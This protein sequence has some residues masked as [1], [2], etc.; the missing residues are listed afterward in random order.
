MNSQPSGRPVTARTSPPGDSLRLELER[1]RRALGSAVFVGG[2]VLLLGACVV[3][4]CCAAG[5][6]VGAG[7]L[8]LSVVAASAALA[9]LASGMRLL[10]S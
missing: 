10:L 8:P 7:A 2:L 1:H 5:G 6:F 4:L 3:F 9:A